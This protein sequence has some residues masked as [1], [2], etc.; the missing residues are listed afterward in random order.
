VAAAVAAVRA[1]PVRWSGC[2]TL[3]TLLAMKQGS[4]THGGYHGRCIVQRI[5]ACTNSHVQR[6]GASALQALSGAPCAFHPAL[7]PD[8]GSLRATPEWALCTSE[9]HTA[10]APPCY[11][12]PSHFFQTETSA[13]ENAAVVG[14]R[15]D[16]DG[17]GGGGA[18]EGSVSPAPRPRAGAVPV[19]R[20]RR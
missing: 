2:T 18:G 15:A 4:V 11:S 16:A 14:A 7:L 9:R 5:S 1:C 20:A 17:G 8:A 12:R 3:P 13:P 19:P 10:A 6:A